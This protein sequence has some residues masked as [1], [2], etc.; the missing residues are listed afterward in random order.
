LSNGEFTL[1]QLASI[2]IKASQTKIQVAE[3]AERLFPLTQSQR[4]DEWARTI[5]V[6]IERQRAAGVEGAEI[7]KTIDALATLV[8][9]NLI[10]LERN[11]L[12]R[13]REREAARI[14][15]ETDEA[16]RSNRRNR[17]G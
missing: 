16:Y 9:S 13:N 3:L 14:E 2:Q 8:A 7:R 1:G 10:A 15:R 6:F 5:A 4:N 17:N 12:D 11:E